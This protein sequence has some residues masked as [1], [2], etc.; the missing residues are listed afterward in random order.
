MQLARLYFYRLIRARH[1]VSFVGGA[2]FRSSDRYKGVMQS[3]TT[4]GV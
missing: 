1:D 2:L 3:V 4:R